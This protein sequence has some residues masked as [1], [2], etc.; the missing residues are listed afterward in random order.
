MNYL[1]VLPIV[2]LLVFMRM[3]KDAKGDPTGYKKVLRFR[4][5][6]DKYIQIYDDSIPLGV[7]L[8]IMATESMGNVS[9]K[10]SA[11]EVGLMQITP[12]GLQ[13]TG[14]PYTMRSIAKDMDKNIEVGIK[15][16]AKDHSL[17][18]DMNLA[19]MAYN[20]D[21][22]RLIR[23]MNGVATSEDESFIQNA[24][25]RY[26]KTVIYHKNKLLSYLANPNI[27]NPESGD[28]IAQVTEKQAKYIT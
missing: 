11:G 22:Q 1:N 17:L 25:K 9:A 10:A 26:L 15:H 14:L 16:L 3:R 28:Y 4:D 23:K 27:D 20:I 5:I 2:I 7:A 6:V 18:S 13:Y 19:I 8:G 24:G 21:R 12:K